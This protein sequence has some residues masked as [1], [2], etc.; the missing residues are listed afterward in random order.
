[1]KNNEKLT[2]EL[3]NIGVI[4]LD[5]NKQIICEGYSIHITNIFAD[6]YRALKKHDHDLL[7]FKQIYDKQY[8]IDKQKILDNEEGK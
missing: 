2:E 4:S 8:Q 5:G 6:A 1:M 3:L 7:S